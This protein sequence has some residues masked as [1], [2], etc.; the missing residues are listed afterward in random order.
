MR[1]TFSDK[2]DKKLVVLTLEYEC[3]SARVA[4]NNAACKM[5]RNRPPQQLEMRLHA[6]FRL[7]VPNEAEKLSATSL[8]VLRQPMCGN[9]PKKTEENAGELLLTAVSGIIE[10]VGQV[11]CDDIFLDVSAGQGNVATQFALQTSAHQCPSIK[12]RKDLA[13]RGLECLH[14]TRHGSGASQGATDTRR[15]MGYPTFFAFSI[16]RGFK[17]SSQ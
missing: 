11:K 3:Q 12:K 5:P 4:W 17:I 2:E 8:V 10:I 6:R 1:T 16:S 13:R 7:L 9:R 15:C 14:F